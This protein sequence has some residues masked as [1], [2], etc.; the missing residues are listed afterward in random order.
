MML[1][2]HQQSLYQILSLNIKAFREG[3]FKL[4][5]LLPSEKIRETLES[6]P[7]S[8]HLVYYTAKSPKIGATRVVSPRL[9]RKRKTDLLLVSLASSSSGAMY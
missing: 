8:Y 1:R 4:F 9:P 3:I 6:K 5:D 2:T 7:A